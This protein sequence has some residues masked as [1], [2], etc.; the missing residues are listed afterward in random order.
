MFAVCSCSKTL[1]TNG[2]GCVCEL[3]LLERR[4]YS[5]VMMKLFSLMMVR[6]RVLETYFMIQP[7]WREIFEG[8]ICSSFKLTR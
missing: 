1:I 3:M 5:K 6:C 8:E 4:E 2:G 7:S